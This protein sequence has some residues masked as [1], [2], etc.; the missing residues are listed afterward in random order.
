[1]INNIIKQ[2]QEG[3]SLDCLGKENN[4]HYT[5]IRK[6]LADS[7][8][9]LRTRSELTRLQFRKNIPIVGNI[10][11]IINGELLGDGSLN[12][13]KFQ[14]GFKFHSS[15]LE[16]AEWL[17]KKFTD[18][19]IP[20]I[21]VGVRTE[22]YN[23]KNY[24]S[25]ETVKTEEFHKLEEKWYIDRRKIIPKDLQITPLVLLHWWLGDGTIRGKVSGM[26]CTDCFTKEDQLHLVNLM[27]NVISI[28]AHL[29][30][31]NNTYRIFIPCQYMKEF[32]NFM[33]DS[34]FF[35]MNYKWKINKYKQTNRVKISK[36]ELYKLYIVENKTRSEVA[37]YFRCGVDVISDRAKKFNILKYPQR[38]NNKERI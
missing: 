22:F 10:L 17:A 16:Y 7:G 5:K 23:N 27:N 38:R 19:N 32:L 25:F 1:M 8:I 12:K 11:E 4:V 21:G 31:I 14:S 30:K 18:N 33:G 26:L 2:Y 37:K 9:S 13:G 24:Y 15:N 35:S 34:P 6:I 3:K 28:R 20:L 29:Q 36:E